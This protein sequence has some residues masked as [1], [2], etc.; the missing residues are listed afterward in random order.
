M[1]FATVRAKGNDHK[2]FIPHEKFGF[3]LQKRANAKMTTELVKYKAMN[4]ASKAAQALW[5][6]AHSH[7]PANGGTGKGSRSGE[8]KRLP[9]KIQN[10][11]REQDY[12]LE[13]AAWRRTLSNTLALLK[14]ANLMIEKAEATIANQGKR[15]AQLEEIATTDELTGLRNRRGFYES[16]VKELDRCERGM[17]CG[18]LL[19]L[20]DLDNFKSAND[21]YG[22]MAGDACLRLMGRT[23]FNEV[24][25]MDVAARLGGD[26]FVLLLSNTTKCEAT[27]RAQELIMRL[28]NL[29]VAW[30]GEEIPVRASL[31]L[32]AFGAG[33]KA[34]TIFNDADLE[35]YEN[36]HIRTKEGHRQS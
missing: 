13:K 29:A 21:T 22:H 30:H 10:N 28:N 11:S 18:G 16:F 24:R 33:D 8:A 27:R 31:G 25:A 4:E 2:N 15:I 23:L 19:I 5:N 32:R 7:N 1:A 9:A 6:G 14:Q 35:L 34:N 36:K 3:D 17:S 20:I 12:V 26:E